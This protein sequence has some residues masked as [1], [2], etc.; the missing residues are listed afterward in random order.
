MAVQAVSARGVRIHFT[1][2]DVG[3]GRVWMH[4]G[5]PV[6]GIMRGLWTGKGPLGD[7]DF[8]TEFV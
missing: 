2:F 1:D 3:A 7:A 5:D 6:N 8:W 4:A